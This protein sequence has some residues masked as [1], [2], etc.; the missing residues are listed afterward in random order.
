MGTLRHAV[1]AGLL[2]SL[3]SATAVAQTTVRIYEVSR[4]THPAPSPVTQINLAD[5][6][7]D[8]RVT[9]RLGLGPGF[10]SY[11]LEV[12][13]GDGCDAKIARVGATATCWQIFAAQPDNSVFTA[14]FRVRDFLAGRTR[15]AEVGNTD[16]ADGC[17]PARAAVLPQV[18]TAHV[19]LVDGNADAAGFATWK[20][21]YRLVGSPPPDRVSA[22]T[23]DEEVLIAFAYDN[24]ETVAA[25]V[26]FYCDPP[27][28]NRIAIP[29]GALV[30]PDAGAAEQS[31]AVS[32]ELVAGA[33]AASLEH[34]RCGSARVA[35]GSGRAKGLVN[36][37]LYNV[38]AA[39]VDSFGNVGAL[40][41]LACAAAQAK[42]AGDTQA[43]ACS[44]GGTS[45][46]RNGSALAFVVMLG[47]AL[48][49]RR[50]RG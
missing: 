17:V 25:D 47:S 14:E 44:F 49:R 6:L 9:L 18:L 4:E 38:A 36:G 22:A 23:G 37:V 28:N 21:E 48:A 40:S 50:R 32:T 20:A 8:D 1:G 31:C 41:Q 45:P 39:T 15:A 33:P 16:G 10:P 2:C 5:C 24:P 46:M 19:M 12:W 7:S 3:L 27:P 34:L 42:P 35:D 11:G 30:D 29:Q 43:Q 26:Q 13:A